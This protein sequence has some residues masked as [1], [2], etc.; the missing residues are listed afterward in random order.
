MSTLTMRFLK[1]A[2]EGTK[3]YLTYPSHNKKSR[4]DLLP[5]SLPYLSCSATFNPNKM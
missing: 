5:G 2:A 1:L 3:K 4:E